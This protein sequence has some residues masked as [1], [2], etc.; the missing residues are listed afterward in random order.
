MKHKKCSRNGDDFV[1]GVQESLARAAEPSAGRG[2][3][4][5]LQGCLWKESNREE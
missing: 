3:K 2:G 1:R 5:A 4:S